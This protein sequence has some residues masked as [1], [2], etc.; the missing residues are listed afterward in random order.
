MWK[1]AL[2]YCTLP[3]TARSALMSIIWHKANANEI[4]P[5]VLDILMRTT[6]PVMMINPIRP[7]R[8]CPWLCAKAMQW[9]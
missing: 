6:S 7:K 8:S 3:F 2:I 5:V 9:L 1:G 4:A